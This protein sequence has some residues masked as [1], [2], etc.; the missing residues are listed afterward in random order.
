MKYLKKNLGMMRKENEK[1]RTGR[2]HWLKEVAKIA[3]R[4]AIEIVIVIITK[5]IKG[6]R[7][8]K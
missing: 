2:N 1:M 3:G 8:W 4:I 7:F 6:V 5:R